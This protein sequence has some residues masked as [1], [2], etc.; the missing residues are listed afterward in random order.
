MMKFQRSLEMAP[1]YENSEA[2]LRLEER[3]RL[4]NAKIFGQVILIG[5]YVNVHMPVDLVRAWQEGETSLEDVLKEKKYAL[6]E[7][8]SACRDG[9]ERYSKILRDLVTKASAAGTDGAAATD[10]ERVDEQE[11]LRFT[12]GLLKL[13]KTQHA[14]QDAPTGYL[15]DLSEEE[16]N[17]AIQLQAVLDRSDPER[18]NGVLTTP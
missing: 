13:T 8:W 14:T 10:G 18:A 4:W 6:E 17:I 12:R 15:L 5:H 16:K 1:S 11:A 7:A 3:E 2:P 9:G